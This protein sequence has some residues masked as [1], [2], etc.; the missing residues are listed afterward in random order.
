M[1]VDFSNPNFI[2]AC[3]QVNIFISLM[4]EFSALFQ[5]CICIFLDMI[6]IFIVVLLEFN[7]VSVSSLNFLICLIKLRLSF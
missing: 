3:V 1:D 6:Q 4:T 7:E 2:S 5:M